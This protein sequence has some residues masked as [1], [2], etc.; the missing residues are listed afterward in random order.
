M[1]IWRSTERYPLGHFPFVPND[2]HSSRTRGRPHLERRRRVASRT[3]KPRRR[4]PHW[5]PHALAR[6]G[7]LARNEALTGT[8][9]VGCIRV[10]RLAW[11]E[12]PP[13]KHRCVG[14]AVPTPNHAAGYP[15]VPVAQRAS[16]LHVDA[17]SSASAPGFR[18]W[19]GR[20]ENPP[21]LRVG[22]VVGTPE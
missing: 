4:D 10:R 21:S 5:V 20:R 8:R 7:V 14:S 13:R 17:L 3:V 11:T 15:Q 22:G 19:Q 2:T 1:V 18:V 6:F 16:V 9:P 12:Q